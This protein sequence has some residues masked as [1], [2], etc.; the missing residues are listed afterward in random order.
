M[1]SYPTAAP[2]FADADYMAEIIGTARTADEALA[3]YR[4]YFDGT[5]ATVT[6]VRKVQPE[7]HG[8]G[9]VDGWAPVLAD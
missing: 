7:R 1:T 3:R 6:A 5:G 9:P 4:D 2:I 8:E